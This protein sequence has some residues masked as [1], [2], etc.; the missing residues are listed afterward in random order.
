MNKSDSKKK[1]MAKKMGKRDNVKAMGRL[2]TG[3]E[4]PDNFGKKNNT[5]GKMPGQKA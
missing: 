1:E 3:A 4:T 2:G 5:T